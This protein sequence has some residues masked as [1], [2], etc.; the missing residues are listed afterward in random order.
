MLVG[1]SCQFHSLLYSRA[2][3]HSFLIFLRIHIV[4]SDDMLFGWVVV[5]FRAAHKCSF[6]DLPM[7]LLVHFTFNLVVILIV[8]NSLAKAL[9]EFILIDVVS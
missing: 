4:D 3:V 5:V 6:E 2:V 9:E 8:G 7:R 1:D